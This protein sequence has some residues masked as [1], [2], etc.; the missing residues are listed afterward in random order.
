MLA[1]LLINFKNEMLC[2]IFIY[3]ILVLIS[4]ILILNRI[5]IIL[6]LLKKA[7]FFQNHPIHDF[8]C[9]LYPII[10]DFVEY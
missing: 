7:E 4:I 10:S 1:G 3:L 2:Y 9:S 8:F 6:I 5:Q